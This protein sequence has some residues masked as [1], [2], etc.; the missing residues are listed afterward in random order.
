MEK[1][2]KDLRQRVAKVEE[3]KQ[4]REDIERELNDV[5]VDGGEKLAPPSYVDAVQEKKDEERRDAVEELNAE[6]EASEEAP[7]A[8]ALEA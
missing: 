1:E 7:P 2:L 6:T 4:R 8:K 3:W 5:W